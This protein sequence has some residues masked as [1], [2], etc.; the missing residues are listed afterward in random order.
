ML[1]HIKYPKNFLSDVSREMSDGAIMIGAVPNYNGIGRIL[2]GTRSAS[3]I[4]PE[5]VNQF[6]K[7][8]LAKTLRESGFEPLYI[9]FPP[10]PMASP[11]RWGCGLDCAGCSAPAP[12]SLSWRSF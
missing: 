10:A 4:F 1:E 11:S 8:S 12:P 3:L 6:T 2:Y 7:Q 9:G 5:H